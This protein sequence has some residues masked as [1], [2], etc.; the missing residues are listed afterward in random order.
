VVVGTV[1]RGEQATELV[2]RGGDVHVTVAV[3]PDG[4]QAV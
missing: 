2:D 1:V 4:D 3:D